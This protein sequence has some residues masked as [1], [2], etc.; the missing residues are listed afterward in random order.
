VESTTVTATSE[1]T[2]P[3]PMG[4]LPRLVAIIFSPYQAY[5]AVAAR[6]RWFGAFAVS[7]LITC[8]VTFWFLSSEVGQA[9][10][11]EQQFEAMDRLREI[12]LPIP[13]EQYDQLEAQVKYA[14]YT[15]VASIVFGSPIVYAVLA[16]I[17]LG[18]FNA[19]MGGDGTFRQVFAVVTHSSFV[20]STA[21]L[22][23]APINYAREQMTSPLRLNAILPMFDEASAVG[24]L[25]GSIDLLHIWWAVSLAIGLGVLYKRRTGPIMTSFLAVYLVLVMIV[26]GVRLAL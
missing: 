24:M 22:I 21:S 25:L 2:L 10:L 1:P 18:V 23:T 6:P 8:P 3:P 20:V 19:L 14:P 11:L 26:T 15:S 9:A 7:M 16:G 5:A 12:G 17:L 4:L 13:D